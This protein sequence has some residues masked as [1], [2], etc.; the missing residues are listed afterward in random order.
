V[1]D[2]DAVLALLALASSESDGA[3]TSFEVMWPSFMDKVMLSGSHRAPLDNRHG[4]YVLAE[5]VSHRAEELMDHVIGQAWERGIV[6]DAAIAQNGA[7]SSA[8]WALRDDIEALLASMKPVQLYDVSLPQVHMASYV[9]QLD[10][11]LRR[12]WPNAALTVFGHVADGNL[13]LFV[14]IGEDRHEDAIDGLVYAPLEGLG[15]SISAEHGIGL[16]KRAYLRH[17]RSRDE[18]AMMRQLKA[19]L[20][21]NAI[22]N[23]GKVIPVETV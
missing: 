15:G 17:S 18:I 3:L 20:D 12:R 11:A 21:P 13:H 8:F 7:Q 14:T 6:E 22:L 23:P 16:E 19:M 4:F 1:A 10:A 5:I 9:E 2:F